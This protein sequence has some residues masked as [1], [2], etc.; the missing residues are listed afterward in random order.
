MS[1]MLYFIKF[2]ETKIKNKKYASANSPDNIMGDEFAVD[3]CG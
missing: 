3:F 2:L 1:T